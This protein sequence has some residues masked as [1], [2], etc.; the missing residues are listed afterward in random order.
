MFELRKGKIV[1]MK[2]RLVCGITAGLFLFGGYAAAAGHPLL[3][4]Q[5]SSL[6]WAMSDAPLGY[7]DYGAP[8]ATAPMTV[9]ATYPLLMAAATPVPASTLALQADTTAVSVGAGQ[10]FSTWADLTA[11]FRPSRWRLPIRVGE[12]LSFLNWRAWHDAPGRTAKVFAGVVV[13]VG[14]TAAIAS[15]GGGGGGGGGDSG[16]R[17]PGVRPP[18]SSPQPPSGGGGGSG[19]SNNKPRPPSGGGGSSGG[20]GGGGSGGGSGGGGGGGDESPF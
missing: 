4:L 9:D 1:K 3:T 16:S 5:D 2:Q 19:G 14:I 7:G 11:V 8:S 13:V 17:D 20:S 18:N 6:A 15:A 10:E 12:P